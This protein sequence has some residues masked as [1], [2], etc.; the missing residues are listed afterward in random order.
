M[1]S[2]DRASTPILSRYP[3]LNVGVKSS[4]LSQKILR[5]DLAHE[6]VL[7]GKVHRTY[8][9]ELPVEYQLGMYRKETSAGFFFLPMCNAFHKKLR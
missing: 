6:A 3:M 5:V 9:R 8:S 2:N 4:Q 7:Y 1:E